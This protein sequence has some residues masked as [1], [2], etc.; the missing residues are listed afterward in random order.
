MTAYPLLTTQNWGVIEGCTKVSAGCKHCY[1]ETH[2]GEAFNAPV[3]NTAAIF[4]PPQW[5]KGQV[6][7]AECGDWLH[8][9]M[10]DDHIEEIFRQIAVH[11]AQLFVGLTKRVER[12]EA[13]FSGRKVPDNLFVGVSVE[14][15]ETA[16]Y[17][18]P[19]L[20][21]VAGKRM[22]SAQPLLGPIVLPDVLVTGC[23]VGQEWGQEYRAMDEALVRDLQQQCRTRKIAF[24]YQQRMVGSERQMFPRLGRA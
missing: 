16:D 5:R 22:V 17:R 7:V 19:F 11:P 21:H 3:V 8:E 10:P 24:N 12:I 9:A 1:A 13:V 6:D 4:N 15:Q 2:L 20:V 14:D 23:I 18:V